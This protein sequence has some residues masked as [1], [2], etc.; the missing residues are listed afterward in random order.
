L[1]LA[2]QA[3]DIA[4]GLGIEALFLAN[5]F[6]E[7][8]L[9][10]SHRTAALLG[11]CQVQHSILTSMTASRKAPLVD[12]AHHCAEAFSPITGR[13]FQVVSRQDGQAGRAYDTGRLPGPR[14]TGAGLALAA[15]GFALAALLTGPAALALAAVAIGTG[16]VTPL[17][18]AALAG[19]A[20]AGRLGQTM[21]AAEVGREL[22]DAG[23]P[24]LVGVIPPAGLSLGL[25]SLAAGLLGTAAWTTTRRPASSA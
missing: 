3:A 4:E 14:G 15:V 5:P 24:L 18:L 17:G 23:G 20:P 11:P 25:L 9:S 12:E 2:P 22:G 19:A 1:R 6:A 8:G 21:G 16:I 7:G 10:T 13:C